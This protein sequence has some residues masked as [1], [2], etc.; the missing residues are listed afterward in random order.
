MN[1]TANARDAMPEGGKLLIEIANVEMEEGA[2][3]PADIAPAHYVTLTVS[4]TGAGMSPEV[5]SRAFDPF[6]TT[7]DIGKGT[8]LGLS[9]V[10]GI[11]KERRGSI[12]VNSKPGNIGCRSITLLAR[13]SE[14]HTSIAYYGLTPNRSAITRPIAGYQVMNPMRERRMTSGRF[15]SR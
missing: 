1:M 8:G 6:F 14:K 5:Q 9:S 3:E 2:G 15:S 13:A 10:Y 4:D 11:V 12:L 7:K